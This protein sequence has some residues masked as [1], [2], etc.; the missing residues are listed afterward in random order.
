M[1]NV[2]YR[3]IEEP[4]EKVAGGDRI[5][6]FVAS[7]DRPDRMGDIIEVDGWDTALWEKNPVILWGHDHGTPPIGR[8][9]GV[10]KLGRP[11]QL[12]IDVQFAAKDVHPLAGTVEGL[13]KDGFIKAVSVGFIPHDS[14]PIDK[15]DDS[16]FA[17]RRY[18]KQELIELS[19][20]SVPANP[21]ALIVNN[22][23]ATRSTPFVK[24]LI[25]YKEKFPNIDSAFAWAA[26][27][28]YLNACGKEEFKK[29]YHL[30][31]A[32]VENKEALVKVDI[33]EGVTALLDIPQPGVSNT[34]KA[35][36]MFSEAVVKEL[37][38]VAR[39]NGEQQSKIIDLLT[40]NVEAVDKLSTV[41]RELASLSELL[42]EAEPRSLS[43]SVP[44]T[45]ED[46]TEEMEKAIREL[47]ANSK[48]LIVSK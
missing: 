27:H 44:S 2:I 10:R 46:L 39:G 36:P 12:Q 18:T 13:V 42:K 6:K 11:R 8:G 48:M 30:E 14:E 40:K 45:E 31:F 32:K 47:E 3:S 38:D 41:I 19:V 20:V 22:S 28:G 29:S 23:L 7:D 35:A 21:R 4:V 17:P 33:G 16:W 9:I 1:D 5:Y 37:I 25:F 15:E 43:A 34:E 26:A 24:G